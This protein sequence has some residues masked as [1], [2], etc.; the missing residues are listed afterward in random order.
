[1]AYVYIVKCD[2]QSYY[3]GIAVDVKKRIREHYNK[4]KTSAKYMRA[5]NIL[6]I[7]AVWEAESLSSAGKLEYYIKKKL[8]HAQKELLTKSEEA[9]SSLIVGKIT[10]NTYKRIYNI[11]LFD[12]I[13]EKNT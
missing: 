1:M 13:S 12:C 10:E 7:S 3:T 2:D 11:T 9:F 8:T 5:R 6:E 4:E